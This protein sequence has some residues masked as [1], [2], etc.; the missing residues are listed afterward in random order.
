VPV[1]VRVLV[2]VLAPEPARLR[3]THSR[4][5]CLVGRNVSSRI[6][7]AVALL[8]L[9]GSVRPALAQDKPRPIVEFVT[10]YAGFVDEN[11]IDRTMIGGGARVFVSRRIAIGPEFVYLQGANSEHDLT[12]TGNVTIDLLREEASAPRR[13]IPYIAAGG[14]YLRQTT[15]VGT[16]PFTSSDGTVSGGVGA[17]IALGKT[18]FI[19]PEVRFGFEPEVRIGVTIGFRPGR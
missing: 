9:G 8:L 19:A 4:A 7:I 10:G 2:L 11:W 14:G 6:L 3:L 15:Q 16:G 1:P 13:V 12:L 17:R 5:G 18:M